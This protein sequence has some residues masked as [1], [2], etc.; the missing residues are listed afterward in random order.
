MEEVRLV[1]TFFKITFEMSVDV[2]QDLNVIDQ[3]PPE[4]RTELILAM[5]EAFRE[6][7]SSCELLSETKV[8]N[9]KP[10]LIETLSI[11]RRIL[12]ALD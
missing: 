6:C 2:V 1:K 4:N 7:I 11:L 12:N 8:D 3:Y 5:K 10:L 9:L